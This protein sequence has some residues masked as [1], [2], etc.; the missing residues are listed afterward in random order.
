MGIVTK[1]SGIIIALVYSCFWF[2]APLKAN[3][4]TEQRNYLTIEIL[5]EKTSDLT[6]KEG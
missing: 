2:S 5:E 6:Q 4:Q 1:F 3:A